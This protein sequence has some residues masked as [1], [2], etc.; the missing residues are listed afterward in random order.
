MFLF[1]VRISNIFSIYVI[2]DSSSQ[3]HKK[4][5]EQCG[6]IKIKYI[7]QLCEVKDII[8]YTNHA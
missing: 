8:G 2:S 3:A 5:K 6:K 7:R 1:E 4:L